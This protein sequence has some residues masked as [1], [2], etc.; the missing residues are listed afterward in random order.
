MRK[1]IGGKRQ[2]GK[3]RATPDPVIIGDVY[4]GTTPPPGEPP[5]KCYELSDGRIVAV[6]EWD[7]EQRKRA[8]NP[9]VSKG[10]RPVSAKRNEIVAVA[11]ARLVNEHGTR[12]TEAQVFDA[13]DATAQDLL[14]EINRT[15]RQRIVQEV[16]ERIETSDRLDRL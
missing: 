9:V 16:I 15:M 11:V 13:V 1:P 14:V 5:G 12:V 6:H 2:V 3:A 7:A 4:N 8:G 10:G